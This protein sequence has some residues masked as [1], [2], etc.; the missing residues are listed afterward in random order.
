MTNNYNGVSTWQIRDL[1]VM[2][3]RPDRKTENLLLFSIRDMSCVGF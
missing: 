2:C 3:S 1:F